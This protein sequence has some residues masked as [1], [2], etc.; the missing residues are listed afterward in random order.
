MYISMKPD[1]V[2]RWLILDLDVHNV[3]HIN[4]VFAF[5]TRCGS[6]ITVTTYNIVIN[7]LAIYID[8]IVVL[9]I[10]KAIFF[11]VSLLQS[12]ST[13]HIMVGVQILSQLVCEM[14]QVSEVNVSGC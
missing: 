5:R 3:S 6:N 14:N 10:K 4:I 7:G 9:V 13:Q 2:K 12:G 1:K 8:S 11:C